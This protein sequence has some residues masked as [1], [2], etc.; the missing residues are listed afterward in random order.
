MVAFPALLAFICLSSCGKHNDN[1]TAV[2][3]IGADGG[4]IGPS[5]IWLSSAKSVDDQDTTWIDVRFNSDHSVSKVILLSEAPGLGDTSYSVAIPVY[6]GGRLTEV[7]TTT[8]STTSSGTP[9]TLFDYTSSGALLRIR[10][11]PGTNTYA[12][13]SLVM[14]QGGLLAGSYHFVYDSVSGATVQ[15][16]SENFTWDG[17]KDISQILVTN[18][19]TANGAVSS[20]TYTSTYDGYVNPY[21][22]VKDLPFIVGSLDN[23]LPMLSAD[24]VTS[25]QLMGSSSQDAYI[26]QYNTNNLPTS[27]NFQF[28]FQ[29]ALKQSSFVYFEYFAQN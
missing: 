6:S 13:D 18:I 10:Y 8:D 14:G 19:D 24:N 23:V 7:Q 5:N 26:Y 2:S 22:T 15:L 21:R 17:Q 16:Y 27:Q 9:T 1:G 3:G 20:I 4:T 28:L 29:G 12:Y 25:L 11:Q